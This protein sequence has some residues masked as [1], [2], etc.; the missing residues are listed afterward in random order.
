MANQKKSFGLFEPLRHP[1]HHRPRTRREL[2][3]Q[4]FMT[5]AGTVLGASMFS[6]LPSKARAA[7][8]A[9]LDAKRSGICGITGGSGKIPFICFDLAGGANFAGSNVLVGGS[10]GQLDLLST[11]GYNKQ[12]LPGN[13]LPGQVDPQPLEGSNGDY[14]DNRLGLYFHSD[15]ALLRGIIAR[16]SAGTWANT[17]GAVIA[18]RSENDTGN[19]P[20]NPMYAINMAGPVVDGVPLGAKG[21]LTTLV[22]SRASESGGNS[23]APLAMINN[24]VRPTKVD[25]PQ[26]VLG[27]VEVGTFNG[28]QKDQVIRVMEAVARISEAKMGRVSPGVGMLDGVDMDAKIKKQI[29]CAYIESAY[30]ADEFFDASDINPALDPDIFGA[31]GIFNQAGDDGNREYLKTASIMKMVVNGLAGAGTITMG[32]YDYHTGDRST[33]ERRDF[34]AGEC[35]GACLEYAMRKGVPLMMYVFSDGSVF[36]NGMVD[37]SGEGRGKGVWTGDNQQ[38]ASSFFLVYNPGGRPMLIGA[39]EAEQAVHQQLGYMRASGDVETSSSP[40]ANNVNLLVQTVMLNYMALHGETGSF[41]DALAARG[42]A[43]GL[44][45]PST[46]DTLTAFQPIVNGTTSNPV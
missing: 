43:S 27:M 9:E 21:R 30:L 6:F 8:E 31:T 24:E 35:M 36:S 23:M 34:Q 40:C 29:E 46:F 11:A 1:D 32:G 2:I 39:T 14:T 20:H 16:S 42:V 25:R 12:G 10:G 4:G 22:G 13:M 3:S 5:G 18:A 19:N 41:V 38:T 28:L 33:G 26:D 17:N 15:S 37:N 45:S 7:L 44:G